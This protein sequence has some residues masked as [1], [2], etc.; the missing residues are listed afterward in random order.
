MLHHRTTVCRCDRVYE[1]CI[2]CKKAWPVET[3]LDVSLCPSHSGTPVEIEGIHIQESFLTDEESRKLLKGCDSIE[4]SQ[5]QS[6]RRKQNFGPKTNFKE[7]KLKIGNFK[8]FPTVFKWVHKKIKEVKIL[9]DYKVIENCSLEY[10]PETGAY[11]DKHIDDCWV[12]GERIVTINI[13]GD[14]YLTLTKYEGSHDKYNLKYVDFKS[15]HSVANNVAIRLPMPV[16]SL[17]VLYGEA[18]YIWEHAV[19]RSDINN[20]RVCIALREFTSWFLDGSNEVANEVLRK[21]KEYYP[22]E[23]RFEA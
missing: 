8:G 9:E 10:R 6:G 5:S 19:T 13:L 17:M 16:N 21:A 20:R 12:W 22:I 7:K 2:K 11:I 3:T 1:Y 4:W 15:K 23:Q 14:S 18:R